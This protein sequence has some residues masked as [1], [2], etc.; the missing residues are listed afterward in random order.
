MGFGFGAAE[1]SGLRSLLMGVSH[2]LKVDGVSEFA[3]SGAD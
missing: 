2:S 3:Q 1:R